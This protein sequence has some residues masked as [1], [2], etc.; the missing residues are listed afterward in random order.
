MHQHLPDN[1]EAD[2]AKVAV[3]DNLP[4]EAIQEADGVV[5]DRWSADFL[6]V[7][8]RAVFNLLVAVQSL[9]V[10]HTVLARVRRRVQETRCLRLFFPC[11]RE[12]DPRLTVHGAIA[13]KEV[14]EGDRATNCSCG[15]E[16]SSLAGGENGAGIVVI[17][18]HLHVRV[19][20]YVSC[21]RRRGRVSIVRH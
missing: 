17:N 2:E 14:E 6:A 19:V 1:G 8:A 12:V 4:A 3:A 10:R 11:C 7:G 13:A 9:V 20:V 16:T 18:A 15:N 5:N 21:R